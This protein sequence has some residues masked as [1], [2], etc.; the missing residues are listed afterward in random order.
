[1]FK[2]TKGVL[3]SRLAI[4]AETL[5]RVLKQLS[6]DGALSIHGNL[7]RVHN[8]TRLQRLARETVLRQQG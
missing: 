3:A 8:R 5:S 4:R 6:D 2:V 1:V 7:V